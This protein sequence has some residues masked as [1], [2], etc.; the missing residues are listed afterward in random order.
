MVSDAEVVDP[1]TR[2]HRHDVPDGPDHG[3]KRTEAV[4]KTIQ[5]LLG[6]SI[7]ATVAVLAYIIIGVTTTHWLY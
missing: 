6:T 5:V 7:V 3:P 1:K 4:T 2:K